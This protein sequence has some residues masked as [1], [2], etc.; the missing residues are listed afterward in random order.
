[1]SASGSRSGK[2]LAGKNT[3]NRLELRSDD[4]RQ[5]EPYKKIAVDEE[6][7]N[8]FFVRLLV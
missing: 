5:D 4:A 1:M 6:G 2:P 3:L 8:R 7:E